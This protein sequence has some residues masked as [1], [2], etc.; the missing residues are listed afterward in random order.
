VTREVDGVGETHGPL[1][2]AL[3]GTGSIARAHRRAYERFPDV[4]QLAAVCDVNEDAARAFAADTP[5]VAVYADPDELLARAPVEAVD[6]CTPHDTHAP[7]AI[8]AAEAGRH[9]L[10]EKPMATS[11]D[12]CRAILAAVERAGV[13]FMVAQ[14]FRHLPAYVGVK[15]LID[16]GE[17][18]RVWS[19]RTDDWLPSALGPPGR[20]WWGLDGKRAGGGVLMMQCVHQIDLFRYYFGDVRNVLGKVWTGHPRMSHGAE[21]RALATL[22]FESGVVAH[23]SGSYVNRAPY[24]F[25]FLVMGDRGTVYTAPGPGA[26]PL[27]QHQA[28]PLVW[29]LNREE[30]GER[31]F[32]PVPAATDGLACEDPFVNE[33]V[34]FARC[35]REGT[36]P[37]SS[38]RDNL[39]TMKALFG[40]YESAR[41]GR[42]VE[43]ADL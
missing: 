12:E 5:A 4:V 36:E 15:A 7:L 25:Q 16:A 6:I 23:V 30:S 20:A 39:G 37:V 18:G 41:T 35:C 40:I 22:E 26:T 9:V 17:L 42:L 11:L 38:G 33:I 34:H 31:G 27:E 14:H 2:V 13:T 32:V 21:D 1:R 28:P 43:L 3:I 10:L 19:A 24:L 29:S 8:A